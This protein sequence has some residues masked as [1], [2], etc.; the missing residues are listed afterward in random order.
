M[1]VPMR[2]NH[3]RYRLFA[4]PRSGLQVHLGCG[5]KAYIRGWL[6]VDANIVTARPDLWINLLHGLPFRDNSV[7]IFY[8]NQVLEHLPEG[9]LPG[10]FAE[11]FRCLEP[12]GG[13]RIGVPHAGNSYRMYVA[14]RHDWFSDFPQNRK[15]LGGRCANYLLCMNEHGALL[16]FSLMEELMTPAGFVDLKECLPVR[17]SRLVGA[18]VL[19]L[20]EESDFDTPHLLVVEGRKPGGPAGNGY[21]SGPALPG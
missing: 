15:S 3:W 8:S 11:L 16:D 20:E 1:A 7:S 21:S 17:E 12:G 4:A 18:E 6:N 2:I 14:G 5:Q 19:M 13:V 9:A 10:V